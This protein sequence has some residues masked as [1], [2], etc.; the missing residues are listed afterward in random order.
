MADA[1]KTALT[2]PPELGPIV[3]VLSELRDRVR[4]VEMER[5][6]VK[7][8]NSTSPSFPSTLRAM[9]GATFWNA[10]NTND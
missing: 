2:I 1:L 3:A 8:V 4:R 7:P 10:M 9:V 5:A 6:S